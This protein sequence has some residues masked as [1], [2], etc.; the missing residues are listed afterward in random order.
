MI[1]RLATFTFKA[2]LDETSLPFLQSHLR[3]MASFS[4]CGRAYLARPIHG[5]QFLLH[6]E[7][8]DEQD[9]QRLDAALRSDPNASGDFFALLGRLSAPP[10]IAQYEVIE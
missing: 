8:A 4:G 10:H 5:Q 1:A 9:L 7:W 6:T 2:G 3:F